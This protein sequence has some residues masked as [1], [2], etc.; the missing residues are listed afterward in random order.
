MTYSI[1]VVVL[2][3]SFSSVSEIW[4]KLSVLQKSIHDKDISKIFSDKIITPARLGSYID[5]LTSNNFHFQVGDGELLYQNGVGSNSRYG[6]V[7]IINLANS[8]AEAESWISELLSDKRFVQACLFDDEYNSIQNATD[9]YS[10]EALGLPYE[11]LPMISNGRPFPLEKQ[12]IDISN[13]PGRHIGRINYIETVGSVMWLGESFWEVTGQNKEEVVHQDWLDVELYENYIKL[14]AQDHLFDSALGE[15]G[16]LQD[17]LRRLLFANTWHQNL[18][19]CCKQLKH[20]SEKPSVLTP[21]YGECDGGDMSN[22]ATKMKI[23]EKVKEV[24][25][26][27]AEDCVNWVASNF[28]S[29]ISYED[30]DIGAIENLLDDLHK[31]NKKN[32]LP[33]ERLDSFEKMFGF[34]IGEVFRRNYGNVSWGWAISD[35]ERVYALCESSTGNALSYPIQKVQKRIENGSEDNVLVYYHTLVEYAKSPDAGG[36][37]LPV[38][39]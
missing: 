7:L 22:N 17:R 23:D 34:Y 30:R 13:H 14:K 8:E 26:T 28:S 35:G 25:E 6:N 24:A 18:Q 2:H 16:E 10:Y 15:Q 3:Q 20:S 5:S 29:R 31:A 4:Q 27:Y 21:K 1:E 33:K 19:P 12:I 38:S 37:G 11:H 36:G 9:P 32:P 39:I